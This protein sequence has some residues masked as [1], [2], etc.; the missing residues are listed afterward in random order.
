MD[1]YYIDM[2]MLTQAKLFFKHA[3]IIEL[4]NIEIYC[5]SGTFIIIIMEGYLS[6]IAL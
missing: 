6:I 5:I 4:P 3:L 2:I 1:I